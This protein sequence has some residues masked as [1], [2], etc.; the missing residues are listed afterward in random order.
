MKPIYD[1]DTHVKALL[2]MLEYREPGEFDPDDEPYHIDELCP[3]QWAMSTK[4]DTL[5][6]LEE[7]YFWIGELMGLKPWCVICRTFIGMEAD[8]N[9]GKCCPCYNMSCSVS[10][11]KTWIALEEKGY[12]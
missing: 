6:C 12:I 1:V 4:E 5:P 11:K 8:Y 2:H 7:E 3:A 10:I 9:S